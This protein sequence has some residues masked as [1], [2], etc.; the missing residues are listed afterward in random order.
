MALLLKYLLIGCYQLPRLVDTKVEEVTAPGKQIMINGGE[1]ADQLN[2]LAYDLFYTRLKCCTGK[3]C[4]GFSKN[5]IKR[6]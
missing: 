2:N 5:F 6:G 4:I 1:C 3:G